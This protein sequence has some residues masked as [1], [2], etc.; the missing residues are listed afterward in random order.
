MSLFRFLL[1][2]LFS[3]FVMAAGAAQAQENGRTIL[4]LDA[5]GSMW[6]QIDGT[7]KI[8]IAQDV[9]G[10]LLQSIPA[11]QDLGL[12]VYGHRRKGDCSD[13][14]TL[15]EPAPGTRDAILKAVN[16][17]K[18]KGKTPL[19]AAVIAAA[20]KLRYTEEKATVILVSDGRETCDFDPCEVGRTLEES[21]VDFTAHVIGFDVARKSDRAQLQCLAENTGGT[22]QTASNAA[23]LSLALKAVSKPKAPEPGRVRFIAIE[24]EDGDRVTANLVWSVT[25]TDTGEA[26]VDMERDDRLNLPLL[27]GNY[28]AEVLLT[29]TEAYAQADIRV[30]ANTNTTVTLVIPLLLPQATLGAPDTALA[31]ETISVEWSGPDDK[32]DFLSTAAPDRRDGAWIT[33]SY[34]KDGAPL[35][36]QMPPEPGTYEIRYVL[37]ARGIAL[38][39]KTIEVLP[40][41]ATIDLPDTALAGETLSLNWTGPDY[42]RDYLST[43]TPGARGSSYATFSYTEGGAPLGLKMPPEPGE[44]EVRYV[45]SQSNTVIFARKIT[46]KAV[47]STLDAPLTAVAG[48]NVA[49]RWS[50]PNY[51]RDY[52]SVAEPGSRDSAYRGFSYTSYGTPLEIKMPTS[53]GAYELRYVLGQ[54]NT[55]IARRMIELTPVSASLTI[56]AS[57]NAGSKLLVEWQ[58]P[59]YER[60]YITVAPR[61]SRPS[62]YVNFSYTSYGSPLEVQMPAQ[63][64]DYVIRYVANASPDVVL[65]EKDI[66]VAPVNATISAASSATPSETL[67]VNWTG[68]DNKG[69]YLAIARAGGNRYHTYV[70]TKYGSP[71]EMTAPEEPGEYEI[72]YVLG[73]RDTVIERHPLTVK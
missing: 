25:N 2:A 19:S 23:E 59:N 28:R 66:H 51:D 4:V 64:G 68:P 1:G 15:V 11:D 34:T 3:V 9:I 39:R 13:I 57:A 63:P 7:A 62:K 27:P 37:D 65:A 20:K 32:K 29:T 12:T 43:A 21:G 55:V 49:V 54:G 17:I 24:G 48:S 72:W 36:L 33:Y 58:G 69:D 61:D 8:T 14:E 38:A 46:V 53:P 60:D 41:S 5:S 35:G 26:V 10:G 22:F 67:N 45:M 16:A 18:P 52:I 47:Q 50:G 44:Y 31:G 56:P 30:S 71:L 40:V 6:G 42:K 70:Y 73:E